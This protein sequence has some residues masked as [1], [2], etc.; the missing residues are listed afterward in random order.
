MTSNMKQNYSQKTTSSM[1]WRKYIFMLS[2]V[3][4]V[5]VTNVNICTKLIMW[6]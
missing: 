3:S 1:K 6:N 2:L 4:S 5:L